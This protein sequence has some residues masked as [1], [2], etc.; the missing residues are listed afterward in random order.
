MIRY[1]REVSNILFNQFFEAIGSNIAPKLVF[2]NWLEYE[3][4][5]LGI[6]YKDHDSYFVF[7]NAGDELVFRLRFGI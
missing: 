4:K 3:C 6:T 1:T 5:K 7:E 2:N